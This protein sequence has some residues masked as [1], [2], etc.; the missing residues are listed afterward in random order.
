MGAVLYVGAVEGLMGT[1]VGVKLDQ[2]APGAGDGKLNGVRYFRCTVRYPP[3]DTNDSLS[4]R[5]SGLI[6]R[7]C[8]CAAS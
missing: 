5:R 8:S 6:T 7:S 1:S 2:P 3:E 4:N